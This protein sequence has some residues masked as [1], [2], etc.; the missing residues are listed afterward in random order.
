MHR[1]W[2][3]CLVLWVSRPSD[4]LCRAPI[5]R[6]QLGC[7]TMRVSRPSTDCRRGTKFAYQL[8]RAPS[9]GGGVVARFGK[10]SGRRGVWRDGSPTPYSRVLQSPSPLLFCRIR[11]SV[12]R[13]LFLTPL[14]QF[15]KYRA[16]SWA[17][18]IHELPQVVGH[19]FTD[20][21]VPVFV[22][23]AAVPYD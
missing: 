5:A 23:N 19:P 2:Q 4:N 3:D 22:I 9:M 15:L 13:I 14:R 1:D 12:G 17:E 8:C 20:F 7:L 10:V 21:F 16:K 6:D 18:Y 11:L